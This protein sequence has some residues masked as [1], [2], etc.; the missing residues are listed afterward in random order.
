MRNL[1]NVMSDV[2]E[3]IQFEQP[4]QYQVIQ[5]QN[6]P[7]VKIYDDTG[8]MLK[9]EIVQTERHPVGL[10]MSRSGFTRREMEIIMDT[11]MDKLSPDDDNAS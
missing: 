1:D 2:V 7:I 5:G 8:C 3:E 10:V 4:L 6:V 11:L 9:I